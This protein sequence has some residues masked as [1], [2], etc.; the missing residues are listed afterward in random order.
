MAASDFKSHLTVCP[1]HFQSP[2]LSKVGHWMIEINSETNIDV[3]SLLSM[4]P[5]TS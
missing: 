2:V 4:L 1:R 5:K 3:Y